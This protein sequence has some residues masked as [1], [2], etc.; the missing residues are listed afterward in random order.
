M[1]LTYNTVVLFTV[2]CVLWLHILK[3]KVAISSYLSSQSS[4]C[5]S[6]HQRI[7]CYALPSVSTQYAL[8]ALNS[9]FIM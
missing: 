4:N 8:L 3:C 9:F 6:K 5:N 7:T 2:Y 1:L